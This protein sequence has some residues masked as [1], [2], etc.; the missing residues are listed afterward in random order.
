[1]DKK[2]WNSD[3][4]LFVVSP[5]IT[6]DKVK[7]DIDYKREA[8]QEAEVGTTSNKNINVVSYIEGEHCANCL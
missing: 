2:R 3:F 8:E 4:S 5:I 6:Q 7:S 1:M